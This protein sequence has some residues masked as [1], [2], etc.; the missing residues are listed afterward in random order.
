M[1]ENNVETASQHRAIFHSHCRTTVA[2]LEWD[3]RYAE[4]MVF[5]ARISLA[6]L[7][8]HTLMLVLAYYA[9][10]RHTVCT[11]RRYCCCAATKRPAI[12]ARKERGGHKA[13]TTIK[14][15][16]SRDRR[17]RLRNRAVGHG[18]R[19]GAHGVRDPRTGFRGLGFGVW[20]QVLAKPMLQDYCC[21]RR[22][23]MLRR[24]RDA[25]SN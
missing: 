4:E 14:V 19:R 17:R 8:W 24:R 10:Y 5:T 20:A 23:G 11:D 25:C 9:M 7:E 12:S 6:A 22:T 13:L 15:D 18:F 21:G 1:R 3:I 16:E 2:V